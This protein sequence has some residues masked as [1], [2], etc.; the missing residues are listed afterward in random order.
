LEKY[1][2]AALATETGTEEQ[3]AFE[4]KHQKAVEKF[5]K[6]FYPFWDPES[7]EGKPH[8]D[9]SF[10]KDPAYGTMTGNIFLGM[11]QKSEEEERKL[12]SGEVGGT[13]FY[14]KPTYYTKKDYY[15]EDYEDK[16]LAGQIKSAEQ[17]RFENLRGLEDPLPEGGFYKGGRVPF[18]KG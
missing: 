10:V 8:A 6:E 3:M 1:R 16:T 18:G 14:K 17:I 5:D 11:R 4:P 7:Y 13:Q 12:R 2:R 9:T 15:P